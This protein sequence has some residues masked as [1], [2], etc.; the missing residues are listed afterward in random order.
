[1]EQRR[2]NRPAWLKDRHCILILLAITLLLFRKALLA[3]GVILSHPV[4]LDLTHHVYSLR[5][6]G[7][8]ILGRGEIPLWNPYLFCGTPFIANWHSAIFYPLNLIFLVMPVHIALNWSIAFHFFLAGVLTYIF[9]NYLLGNKF[10][11]LL[12]AITFVFS[13]PY[14]VQL[15]PGHVFNP[16]PWLPLSLLLAELALRRKQ[17]VYYVLGG[18]V[19]ALQVLAGHPQYMLYCFGALVLYFLAGA[20]YACHE[21]R[22]PAPLGRVCIGLGVLCAVGFSLSA[23]QLFPSL[24]YT[25]FSSRALLKGPASVREI[26]FP[27]ENILTLAAPGFWGDMQGAR[28]WGRWL[29]WETCLYVGIAP[30]IL[31]VVGSCLSRRRHAYFFTG[32][33]VL[34]LILAFGAYS[35]LFKFFYYYVPGFSLFRGQA[36]FIFLTTFSLAVLAGYGCEIVLERVRTGRRGLTRVAVMTLLAAGVVL[37]LCAVMAQGGERSSLWQQVLRYRAARGFEGTPPLNAAEGGMAHSAYRVTIQGVA[38][39][40]ILMGVAGV[41]LFA[42]ARGGI[43]F[44]AIGIVLI[45]LSIADLW[46]F[47]ARYIMT[48]P[49]AVCSWPRGLVDSLK[50]DRTPFRV[51]T[52]NISIPGATQNMNDAIFAIDGYE[53]VNVGCYKEYVDFSQ[54]ISSSDRLTFS[55]ERVTPMFEALNLK[56]VILPADQQFAMPGYRVQFGDGRENVYAREKP[57]PRAYVAHEARIINDRRD[58]LRELSKGDFAERGL[59]LFDSEPGVRLPAPASQMP[60]SQATI[61]GDQPGNTMLVAT[62]SRPGFLVLSDTYYPGWKAYVDGTE[63]PILRGNYAFRAVYCNE[64]RHTVNFRYEPLSFA[65]GVRV[66]IVSLSLVGVYFIAMCCRRPTRR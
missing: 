1:M 2:R 14:I 31:A 63:R 32:L 24:E 18:V 61:T 12:A 39:A 45:A 5:R 22:S 37:L 11:A 58:L 15:F 53:T 25:R 20:I 30:L 23:V 62:L 17:V 42:V 59:V 65:R 35:P 43:P 47:G 29:F 9:V 44:P 38:V 41:I 46:Y 66:S 16:L 55:I 56:Y 57:S 3:G 54:G 51:C 33:A 13:G 6:F 10:S 21:E 60:A 49:L 26:S 28:Y 48:S 36:K 64:G 7:F 4:F 34:S 8:N 19:L 27:P 40:G 50:A 52:P